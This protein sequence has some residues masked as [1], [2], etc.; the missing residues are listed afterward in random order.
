M[1][2]S[3][4]RMFGRN[5]FRLGLF[6]MNCSGGLT[7][8]SIPDRWDASW[9]NNLLAARMADEAGLEFLLPIGRWLGYKGQM[10]TEGTSFETLTWASSLLAATRGVCVFGTLHVAFMNPVFAAKQIVTADHVGEGRFGLNIV[11]G[12]NADE[13]AMFGIP[14]AE[15]AARYAYTE[16]WIDVLERIWSESEPFDFD[17]SHFRLRGVL[18]KPKPHGGTRPI[19][20]SAGNS[21][22]GRAFAARHADCLF[23][24]I[25]ELD[26]LRDEIQSVRAVSSRA[27]VYASGHLICRATQQEADDYYRY[28]VYECGDWEAAEH[29]AIIR[30][31][32]RTTTFGTMK[33]LKERLIS[34]V[35]TYPVVGSFDAVA[36]TFAEMSAAGLDGIALGLVNYVNDLP[37]L[38]DEVLP[39]L[40][41]LGLRAA[42]AASL[43]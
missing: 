28:L 18:G 36:A 13:F 25:T 20:I 2:R 29:A 33:R 17:G 39:R 19:L 10:D 24:T 7:M 14:L 35:G 16:E 22:D 43:V 4:T 5:A 27:G 38:R 12:W 40:E 37:A 26:T 8:A 30:T 15:H 21:A 23:M 11:S 34:G 42:A 1:D 31:R 32:N 3:E 41:R 6:G 9:K